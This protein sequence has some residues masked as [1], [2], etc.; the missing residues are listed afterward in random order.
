L[1][2]SNACARLAYYSYNNSALV[3]V[4]NTDTWL[5]FNGDKAFVYGQP[6]GQICKDPKKYS[7]AYSINTK[8]GLQEGYKC[9]LSLDE[10]VKFYTDK[11]V[12]MEYLVTKATKNFDVY[13]AL[14]FLDDKGVI[15]LKSSGN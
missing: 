10:V 12:K 15:D 4:R 11:G 7:P 5:W 14:N 9:V 8:T 13:S 2:N 6:V 1:V 3:H